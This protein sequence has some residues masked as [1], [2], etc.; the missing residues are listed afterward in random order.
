MTERNFTS[1]AHT[2]NTQYFYFH[3]IYITQFK[4][5]INYFAQINNNR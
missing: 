2:R 1:S 4:F 3:Y 5:K